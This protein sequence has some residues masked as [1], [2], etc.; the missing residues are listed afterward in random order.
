MFA[1]MPFLLH[2]LGFH[3]DSG[4]NIRSTSVFDFLSNIQLSYIN[5]TEI[6]NESNYRARN[7][8]PLLPDLDCVHYLYE[9]H[10]DFYNKCTEPNASCFYGVEYEPN[11]W[12]NKPRCIDCADYGERTLLGLGGSINVYLCKSNATRKI[13]LEDNWWTSW[14]C[15]SSCIPPTGYMF[16]NI[17]GNF[18]CINNSIC[19]GTVINNNY[20]YKIDIK[21][22]EMGAERLYPTALSDKDYKSAVKLSCSNDFKP[23]ITVFKIPIFDYKIWLF[24]FVLGFLIFFYSKFIK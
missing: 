19:G 22:D 21:L 12:S 7:S 10:N 1:L 13:G 11:F 20:K 8:L 2:L 14:S 17:T 9:T 15:G 23:Q 4:K 16:S 6:Y 3:C 5:P 18:V 24:M